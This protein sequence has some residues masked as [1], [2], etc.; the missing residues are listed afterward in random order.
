MKPEVVKAVIEFVKMS[1]ETIDNVLSDAERATAGQESARTKAA[2]VVNTLLD[3]KLIAANE[4]PVAEK[5][6]STL[7][8]SLDILSLVLSHYAATEKKANDELGRG[9]DSQDAAPAPSY[10][11]ERVPF[12]ERESD[13]VL[14]RFADR[15]NNR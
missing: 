13:Q 9:V 8:G 4:R 7:D 11:V 5:M 6:A 15:H 2:A 1:S 10:V 3:R 12:G 14:R